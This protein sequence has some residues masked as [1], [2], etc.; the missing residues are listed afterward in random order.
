MAETKEVVITRLGHQG[1]GVVQ[2]TDQND[3]YVPL[4]LAGEKVKIEY[5]DNK[6]TLHSIIESSPERVKPPCEHYKSCG[7][8][9]LQHL[10]KQ[11]YIEWKTENI[12]QAF[13]SQ[14]ITDLPIDPMFVVEE[15]SRRRAVL[16]ARRTKKTLL[17]GF[18]GRRTHDIIDINDCYI[19]SPAIQSKLESLKALL[20]P[21]I[22]RKAEIRLTVIEADNGL[23]IALENVNKELDADTYQEIANICNEHQIARLTIDNE[24]IFSQCTPYLSFD[25][26]NM[27]IASGGFLQAVQSAQNFMTSIIIDNLQDTK[28]ALDLFSGMGTFTL[29]MA[30]KVKV[31]AVESDKLALKSLEAS[32]NKLQEV[33]P[34]DLVKRDL[35]TD[36]LMTKE[37]NAYDFVVM[38]PPRSGAIAQ[39]KQLAGSSVPTIVCVSCNPATL[40]RDIRALIDGGYSLL[41]IAPVDQFLYSAHVEVIAILKR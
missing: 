23:D 35:F 38:D 8:C 3:L 22:S 17:L 2:S 24:A 19:L 13:K 32:T 30:K 37:L 18:H 28:Q 20:R 25:N 10:S 1:D 12:I 40:A 31:T 14:G 29:P 5:V 26:I 33:K 9:N 4:A 21:L 15:R 36:P 34:I 11:A 6:V 7:G 41:R 39:A 16:G 27:E